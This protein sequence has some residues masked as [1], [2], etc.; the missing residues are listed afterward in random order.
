MKLKSLIKMRF[1]RMNLPITLVALAALAAILPVES[2]GADSA[3]A[4]NHSVSFISMNSGLS[5]NLVDDLF[6][7]SE[8]Y[9]WI[10]TSASLARYDGYEFVNFTPNS[11]ERRIKSTFVRKVAEDRFGRLWVASDG[12]IDIID[13]NQMSVI[14]MASDNAE[15]GKIA[16]LPSGYVA[17]DHAGNVW[18]RN[19]KM[20][21]CIIFDDNGNI[22]DMQSIPHLSTSIITTGALKPLSGTGDGVW[23]AIGGEVCHLSLENGKISRR[24]TSK[25]LKFPS[26]S[27]ISD[28]EKTGNYIWISTDSG[29]YRYDH[30]TG[31]VR[32]YNE[33]TDGNCSLSR[34]FITALAV[35]SSGDL[36]AGSLNGL[37]IY[38]PSEDGFIKVKASELTGGTGLNNN[39]INCLLT[40][41]DNLWVGTEGC[42]INLLSPRRLIS[43]TFRHSP[44]DAKSISPNPVNAIY[45]DESG[46]IWIGTVEGGLNRAS[47]DYTEGFSHF[48]TANAGLP[49]NTVST[50]TSDRAGHLWVGTWGGG[51]CMFDRSNPSKV[52]R[53]INTGPDGRH[54]DHIGAIAYDP[55]NNLIWIGAN[56]GIFIYNPEDESLK[57]PFKDADKM[58]GSVAV[59][60]APD[61]RLLMGSLEGL[62]IVNLKEG[63]GK[64]S[65]SY[66]HFQYKFDNPESNIKEKVNCITLTENGNIWIGTNGNGI[67]RYESHNGEDKFINYNTTDGLPNDV[68]HGLADDKQGNLWIATYH[69]LSCMTPENHFINFGINNGLDTEQFYWN[70]YRRLANGDILFGSVDG[71]VAVKG[72]SLSKISKIFPVRFTFF[73]VDNHRLH[74]YTDAMELSEN[75]RSFEIGFS[76]FDYAGG[77]NGR[78]YYRMKGYDNDWNTLHPGRHSVTYMNLA[79]GEYSL[80]VKYVS[81]GQSI[82]SVPVSRFDICVTPNFYRRWWFLLLVS[83]AI[84]GCV[85]A[86]YRWRVSD[87]T[88]QRNQ[89]KTAVNE[90]VKE[91]SEQKSL[92]ETHAME[93]ATQN[94][95]L[96]LR[97]EQIVKQKTQ[98]AEMAGKV[99]KLTAD[100]ISFFT[101][102]THEFRTPI[103]LII[104]PI[105]RALKLSTNPKVIEQLNFV[106]KNSRYLLS[107][108]NQLMDFR[109]IESG[110]MEAV[111]KRGNIRELME[112]I[113]KPFEAYAEERGIQ[114][115]TIY[116]LPHPIFDFNE[117]AMRKVVTNLLGNAIKFTPDNGCVRIYISTFRSQQCSGGKDMFYLCVSDNGCGIKEE[118]ISKVFDHFYQGSS[119]IKYPLI[120]A[121]DSGIG[122][123]LCRRLVELYGG[124]ITARNNH[125][126]GC[127]FRVLIPIDNAEVESAVSTSAIA[128]NND[129][130]EF[131]G[132][133][134]DGRQKTV[135]VVEDNDDMRAFMRSVLSDHY[136]VEEAADGE[137]ALHL[138][139]TKDVDFIISDLMM[140]G[141]DGLELASKV[142]ENFAISH[143]PFVML[144]A[145]T[146]QESRME[147]YR[148][149][150]DDYILKPF[151]EDMLLAR[152]SNI[153][154]NKQ[155]YQRRFMSDMEVEHLEINEESRDKKFV[156]KV[157]EVLRNNYSNSYYDVGEFAEALGVSRSLLNKK[158]QSL[159][160]QSANQLIR[161]YRLKLAH[162]LIL[163]NRVT[164]NMNVSEIAFQ[165]G[166]NDSKYFTRCFTKQF[167]VNPSTLLREN[168]K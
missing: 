158:L 28:F 168:D 2:Q 153:L 13:L 87:L 35:T 146:S 12:G 21:V 75:D 142:K 150:V 108:I 96:I 34:S 112:D 24:N 80:E 134:S 60:I 25:D 163:Q 10:A 29:L 53:I 78:Y 152:I 151:D 62:L 97:N 22:K 30:S 40:E 8:G 156:D 71:L 70:A 162:E 140:P 88:R 124:T 67:Y 167:G 31:K 1:G 90:G 157:M 27:Y 113:I 132:D 166:F 165:V 77:K 111:T 107:L 36:V 110:K 131:A 16:S 139:L 49:H 56:S 79:P 23:T 47:G 45:E 130:A 143:I 133:T 74:G 6:L 18:I 52:L 141:M 81:D 46:I 155:R 121:S 127:S 102:I 137:E 135:L 148:R 65:F 123:Y 42:G 9:V 51:L 98:L 43:K 38:N 73:T 116:H 82:D 128:L 100:R 76:A 26:S 160:G 55:Y 136:L 101:N 94:R 106:E 92:I 17:A 138:L 114:M 19:E 159:M 69:G 91:I 104:G 64:G 58:P 145:K 149:G 120:G 95:E 37:N 7:D 154:A 44:S 3:F 4:E 72:L 144:T 161:T 109:K 84:A 115:K 11:P 103:T 126:D 66:K 122:L 15:Y 147:G 20:I 57:V 129:S 61:G 48:T 68:V 119:Q 39:F 164:R 83:V 41:G 117:D 50:I 33:L 85:W 99:Q 54:L 105:E 5:H 59:A 118:D 89:L 63:C 32:V 125:G 86:I 93:L 14:D